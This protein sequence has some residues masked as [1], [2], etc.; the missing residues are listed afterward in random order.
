MLAIIIRL[1]VLG[2]TI[3]APLPS[4]NADRPP[5]LPYGLTSTHSDGS[6][7]PSGID[8]PFKRE[9]QMSLNLAPILHT[10]DMVT[11]FVMAPG[12]TECIE[13][14]LDSAPTAKRPRTNKCTTHNLSPNG[15]SKLPDTIKLV[16]GSF[17]P[18][19]VIEQ[20]PLLAR[21]K[22]AFDD[23]LKVLETAGITK[24]SY[25]DPISGELGLSH[26]L[27]QQVGGPINQILLALGNRASWVINSLPPAPIEDWRL[28]SNGA[29]LSVLELKSPKVLNAALLDLIAK[30]LGKFEMRILYDGPD[31]VNSLYSTHV[32]IPTTARERRAPEVLMMEQVRK[33]KSSK[34]TPT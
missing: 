28:V 9:G 22:P 1:A 25:R 31:E 23:T 5:S 32:T 14:A 29:T 15:V 3:A 20:Y 10:F 21:S 26:L 17:N 33:K 34:L 30:N 7:L 27:Y 12:S 19:R 4:H 24:E 13:D 2:L 6:P 18:A 8:A 16:R 11:K